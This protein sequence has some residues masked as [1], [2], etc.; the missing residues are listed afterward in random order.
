MRLT[1]FTD[2]SLR[3]LLVLATRTESLVTI[4]DLSKAFD[5]S[6]AHLMKVTHMLGKSGWGVRY[7]FLETIQGNPISQRLDPV[8]KR[9]LANFQNLFGVVKYF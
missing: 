2:Y 6:Q 1:L 4:A 5:I 7:A 8:G 9:R 3:V